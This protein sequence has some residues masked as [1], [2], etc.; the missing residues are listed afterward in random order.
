LR[1]NPHVNQTWWDPLLRALDASSTH[2]DAFF[3]SPGE[4][5]DV[6]NEEA[7]DDSPF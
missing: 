6:S 4:Q 5:E 2:S 7:K 3:Q 1:S